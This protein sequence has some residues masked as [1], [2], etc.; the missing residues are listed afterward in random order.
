MENVD[1]NIQKGRKIATACKNI[2]KIKVIR[3][4]GSVKFNTGVLTQ[5]LP[6][7][8]AE[9]VEQQAVIFLDM[10][11]CYLKSV[12]QDELENAWA[13]PSTIPES[14]SVSEVP[15]T[16]NEEL[17]PSEADDAVGVLV[18]DSDGE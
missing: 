17:E 16:I 10:L 6:E 11:G 4:E 7:E 9:K 8:V 5:N 2:G 3:K 15:M 1:K 13:D 18:D 14:M 12:A